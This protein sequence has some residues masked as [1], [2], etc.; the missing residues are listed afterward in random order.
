MKRSPIRPVSAKRQASNKVRARLVARQLD[1][2]PTCQAGLEG[3]SGRALDVH[4]IIQRSA[5]PGAQLD[6]GLFLSLCRFCHSY[7]TDQWSFAWNHGYVLRGWQDSRGWIVVADRL[8]HDHCARDKK[9]NELHMEEIV[10]AINL[11]E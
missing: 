6:A 7:I 11:E 10:E 1:K 3:C 5:R 9:C 2:F 8:R 4:E